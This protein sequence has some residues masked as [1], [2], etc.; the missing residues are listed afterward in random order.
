MRLS[1]AEIIVIPLLISSKLL[2]GVADINRF[3]AN[4]NHPE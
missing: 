3:K 4:R 1:G 2:Y